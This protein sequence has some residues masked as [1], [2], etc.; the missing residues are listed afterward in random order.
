LHERSS[1]KFYAMK[2]D[3]ATEPVEVYAG[4]IMQAGLLK[5][6]LENAEIKAYL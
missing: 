5:S 1:L 4:D 6:L 3:H 2:T